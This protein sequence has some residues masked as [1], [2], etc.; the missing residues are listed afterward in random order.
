M[1]KPVY[2]KEITIGV[3]LGL[4][5][6]LN[7]RNKSPHKTNT[8]DNPVFIATNNENKNPYYS[9]T[10]T[11]KLTLPDSVWKKVLTP[12]VYEVARLAYTERAFTGK[13]WNFEGVGAY[14]CA[15]CGNALFLSDSKFASQCGWPSFFK[16]I[17]KNSIV[18]K[19][20]LS[21]GMVRVETLCGRCG[22]HLGHIFDDGPEPTGKRYCMNS[23][24]LDFEPGISKK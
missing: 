16:T 21:Y 13:Y 7:C 19:D 9:R 3:L 24:M 23:V 1:N 17:R 10:D 4:F 5:T 11:T 15:A 22:G 18:Y 20:D 14:Y 2:M 6:L 12:E 8:Y